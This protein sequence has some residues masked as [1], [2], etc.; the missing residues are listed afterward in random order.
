MPNLY[1]DNIDPSRWEIDGSGFLRIRT[2]VLSAG[3]MAYTREELGGAG[4]PPEVTDDII[5]LVVMPDTVKEP[6]GIRS[7]EGMPITVMHADINV[8]NTD[9]QVG[10]VAGAPTVEGP[11]LC[12][13]MRITDKDAIARIVSRELVELSSAYVMEVIWEPGEYDGAPFHGKQTKLRYDHVAL[14]PQGQG[15]AGPDV[16]VLNRQPLEATDMADVT[17][18][19]LIKI[20]NRSFAVSNEQAQEIANAVDEVAADTKKTTSTAFNAQLEEIAAQLKEAMDAKATA[21]A[22]VAELQGQIATMKEQLDAA[23]A[24]E[25]VEQKAD[26][27]NAERDEAATV[28]NS[29]T[30]APELKKLS[31]HNLR[32]AVIN[33]VR[34]ASKL[35]A[36]TEADLKDEAT[37]R[38]RYAAMVE[39]AKAGA[40][41]RKEVP[42]TGAGVVVQNSGDNVAAQPANYAT[43]RFSKLYPSAKPAA[44]KA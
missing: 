34:A 23:G 40:S 24:P 22:K 33:S 43:E 39:N 29:K 37:I 36:L 13:D 3:V 31:G 44:A 11:Y 14:L 12:A 7:L 41:T 2:R 38:G 25:A 19:T 28:M 20:G 17:P 5:M 27:L 10:S 42:V 16:K 32:V 18:K 15:R 9:A 26:A 4:I 30:L 21:D 1:K 8:A 6:R 35:P